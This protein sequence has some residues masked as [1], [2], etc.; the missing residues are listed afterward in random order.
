IAS[1]NEAVD[2]GFLDAKLLESDADLASI[3]D[4]PPFNDIQ[5]RVAQLTRG[6]L[7]TWAKQLL[8]E[9]KP[10]EFTFNRPDASSNKLVALKDYKGRI[11]IVELW[12]TWCPPC[13]GQVKELVQLHKT[14]RGAGLEVVGINCE[15]TPFREAKKTVH[16]FSKETGITYT[17]LLGNEKTK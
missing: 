13:R 1:L 11:L 6:R 12:A 15:G 7:R 10:F 3:R 16:L 2:A 14:Y 17:C 9:Q 5:K 4:K 8:A